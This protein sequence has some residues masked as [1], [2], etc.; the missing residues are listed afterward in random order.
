MAL[1]KHG[2]TIAERFK[3]CTL[4][5]TFHWYDEIESGRK[6]IE[7]RECK[8][9]NRKRIQGAQ[10]VIF[11]R[12]YTKTSMTFAIS[13]IYYRMGNIEI[14]LGGKIAWTSLI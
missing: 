1:V 13:A 4:V 6:T 7:Y 14:H 9:Y 8:E 10:Y 12:G 5:C 11:R 2:L 3:T